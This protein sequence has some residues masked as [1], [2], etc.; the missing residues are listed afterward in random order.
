MTGEMKKAIVGMVLCTIALFAIAGLLL[1]FCAQ[2]AH[3]E[4]SILIYKEYR[5]VPMSWREE[6]VV[7]DYSRLR[8]CCQPSPGYRVWRIGYALVPEDEYFARP[9]LEHYVYDPYDISLY[10]SG[11]EGT[12]TLFVKIYRRNIYS[13]NVWIETVSYPV[14]MIPR[15][16]LDSCHGNTSVWREERW[17]RRPHHPHPDSGVEII[18]EKRTERS[19][20]QDSEATSVGKA[21][22]GL[23]LVIGGL[24]LLG[25]E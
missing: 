13:G 20:D 24:I 12:F 1:L 25:S 14:I 22:V 5:F 2:D 16:K 15:W 7:T 21:I 8:V 18:H 9:G 3:G 17:Q 23:G 19:R 11:R 10:R 6:I 4:V